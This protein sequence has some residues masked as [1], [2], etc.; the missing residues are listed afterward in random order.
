MFLEFISLEYTHSVFLHLY[1]FEVILHPCVLT[2]II[3]LTQFRQFYHFDLLVLLILTIHFKM[4]IQD[5]KMETPRSQTGLLPATVRTAIR[6]DIAAATIETG[7]DTAV[8]K[9]IDSEG[10]ST[11]SEVRATCS[12]TIFSSTTSSKH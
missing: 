11:A 1:L 12:R 4:K 9:R 8:R 6:A 10:A 7:T 5:S 3:R 2:F